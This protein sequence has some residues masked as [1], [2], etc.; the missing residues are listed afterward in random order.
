MSRQKGRNKN[1]Y[2][3]YWFKAYQNLYYVKKQRMSIFLSK[4][5]LKI[6][7]KYLL[8]SEAQMTYYKIMKFSGV[9]I[10]AETFWKL[11]NFFTEIVNKHNKWSTIKIESCY[12][13]LLTSLHEKEKEIDI[14]N[15]FYYKIYRTEYIKILKFLYLSFQLWLFLHKQVVIPL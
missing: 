12:S 10:R 5:E 15:Y 3:Y 9:F 8:S 6:I 13:L 2:V 7:Y 11:L 1:N 14:H 4:I